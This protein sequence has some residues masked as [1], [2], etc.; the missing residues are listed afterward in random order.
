[1]SFALRFSKL[2]QACKLIHTV[3]NDLV[4]NWKQ[5]ALEGF[6]ASGPEPWGEE[7]NSFAIDEGS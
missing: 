4:E 7:Y 2:S 3:L 6:E 5:S 1:M